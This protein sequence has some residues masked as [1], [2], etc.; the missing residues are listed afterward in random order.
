MPKTTDYSAYFSA[1]LPESFYERFLAMTAGYPAVAALDGDTVVGFA[2]L[3]AYHPAPALKS[4]A[5]I[6][7]FIHPDHT[8]HGLGERL[9]DYLTKQ[10]AAMGV[11]DIVASVSSLNPGSIAFHER[12]GFRQVGRLNGVGC[13]FGREFDVVYLQRSLGAKQGA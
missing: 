2:F 11:T 3:R 7:Y 13:K 6:T 8:R 10:A 9:L 12:H 4:C 1:P 5:E